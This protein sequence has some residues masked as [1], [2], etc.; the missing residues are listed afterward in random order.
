M[1]AGRSSEKSLHVENI[2]PEDGIKKL[3][4]NVEAFNQ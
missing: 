3:I 2:R 4:R 1:E